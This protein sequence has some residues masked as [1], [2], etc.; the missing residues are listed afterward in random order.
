MPASLLVVDACVGRAAGGDPTNVGF[1]GAC[2]RALDLALTHGHSVLMSPAIREEWNRH[3]S[4]FARTWR[5]G[6][7]ARRRVRL[8]DPP[9]S[10]VLRTRLAAM[11]ADDP[12]RDALE[13][14]AH[15]VEAALAAD[16]VVLTAD[17]R[18]ALNLN[19][20]FRGAQV[21]QEIVWVHPCHC[22]D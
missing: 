22:C 5:L 10:P 16:R 4:G 1:S 21:F 9:E 17:R 8:Q 7:V 13:K 19:S 6:M 15:L 11:D 3:Q 18:I 2:R 14:D 12:V 20:A